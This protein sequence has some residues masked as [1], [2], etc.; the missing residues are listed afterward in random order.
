VEAIA[1]TLM[2]V[3][4]RCRSCGQIWGEPN[5][6]ASDTLRYALKR[7]AGDWASAE[8]DVT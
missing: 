3:Y 8:P 5:P 2:A 4:Y 1:R 6:Q 7:R